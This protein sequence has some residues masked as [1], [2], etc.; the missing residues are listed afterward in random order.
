MPAPQSTKPTAKAA[1]PG[2]K[3]HSAKPAPVRTGAAISMV[4]RENTSAHTPEGISS[5]NAVTDQMAKSEEIC[6]GDNPASVN[7]TAY[8]G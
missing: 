7:S 3:V 2:K 4:R 5:A 6:A 8:T 1:Y